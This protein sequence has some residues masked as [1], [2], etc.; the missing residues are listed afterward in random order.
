MIYTA[1]LK[2]MIKQWFASG[3]P[4]TAET[5]RYGGLTIA[6]EPDHQ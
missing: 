2:R 5:F 1:H 4:D 6:Y 3:K